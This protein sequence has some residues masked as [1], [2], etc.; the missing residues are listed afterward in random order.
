M[1]K[2]QGFDNFRGAGGGAQNG[3]ISTAGW[4]AGDE[5][6][7]GRRGHDLEPRAGRRG[8]WNAGRWDHRAIQSAGSR[9]QRAGI[10]EIAQPTGRAANDDPV[11]AEKRA[12]LDHILQACLGLEV[13]TTIPQA[14]VVPGENDETAPFGGGSFQHVRFAGWRCAI[15]EIKRK[16]SIGTELHAN[17][18]S[19]QDSVATLPAGTP[20]TQPYWLRE[21]GTPG[22]FRVDDPSLIGRP[23]NPPAFP[24][25]EV[26]EV[27]GQTLVI[28]DEP[29]QVTTDSGKGEIRRRLDVIPP[30][31]LSFVSDVALICSRHFASGRS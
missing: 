19:S 2:T 3:V 4:R 6:Y 31:S 7:F 13:E 1:H 23:E 26:F 25:E 21:E 22:M 10:V 20:L 5:R 28:P 30:V 15:P 12:Q 29:V 11:V 18:S 27:G 9:R 17:E 16:V 14:E 24:V 8:N